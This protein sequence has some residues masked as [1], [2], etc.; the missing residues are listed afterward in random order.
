MRKYL[1]P[2]AFIP[3]HE[4]NEQVTDE[5]GSEIMKELDFTNEAAN[6]VHVRDCQCFRL[7]FSMSSH[8]FFNT[9]CIRLGGIIH[10]LWDFK[11][12]TSVHHS[13]VLFRVRACVYATVCEC[14][15]VREV[16]CMCVW[17]CM[18]VYGVV[19]QIRKTLEE[20]GLP[21]TLPKVVKSMVSSRVL[22]M[23]FISGYKL[24]EYGVLR[25]NGAD[26]KELTRLVCE[27]LAYQM[28]AWQH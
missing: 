14:E 4:C 19:D 17:L 11:Q 18:V 21:I 26:L 22:V 24:N 20:S 3:R 1:H 15:C 9:H 5:W 8:R 7:P 25:R 13:Y 27:A 2:Y 12:F 10:L 23:Q 16:E 6:L 28:Y